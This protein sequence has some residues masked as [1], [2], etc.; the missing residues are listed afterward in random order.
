MVS[1]Y[2]KGI[3][4]P[5][6]VDEA[7]SVCCKLYLKFVC[8]G[9]DVIRIGL[10]PTDNIR[11]GRDLVAGPFHPAFRNLVESKILNDIVLYLYR[12]Q[13]NRDVEVRVSGVTLS[14][15]FADKRKYFNPMV[16]GIEGSIG[17]RQDGNVHADTILMLSGERRFKMSIGDYSRLMCR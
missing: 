13:H 4:R 17:V 8:S 10:Q 16:G 7:V 1:M 11:P 6:T 15:L 5:L 3:F 12:L 9:I 2:Q 14:K